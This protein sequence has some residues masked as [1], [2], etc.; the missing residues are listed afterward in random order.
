MYFVT[1]RNAG[2]G[3][4]SFMAR[5]GMV[6]SGGLTASLAQISIHIPHGI[7]AGFALIS[8]AV[9]LFLPETAGVKL[10]YTVDECKQIYGNQHVWQFLTWHKRLADHSEMNDEKTT[11]AGQRMLNSNWSNKSNCVLKYSSKH[12]NN[13]CNSSVKFNNGNLINKL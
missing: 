5:I 9:T 1:C 6:M 10:P 4:C 8:T 2:L 3:S 11:E 7:F 13:Q 12:M